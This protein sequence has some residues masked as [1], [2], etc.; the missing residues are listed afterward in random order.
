M[1]EE[2]LVMDELDVSNRLEAKTIEP[3]W[4]ESEWFQVWLKL[5]RHQDEE[6]LNAS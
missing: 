4:T 6:V 5:A 3:D 1:N 2:L